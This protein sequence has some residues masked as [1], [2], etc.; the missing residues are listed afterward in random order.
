[1][2]LAQNKVAQFQIGVDCPCRAD[3][4]DVVYTVK[5]V[6][7]VAVNAD[8]RYAHATCHDGNALTLVSARVTLHATHVVDKHGVGEVVFGNVFGAE[9]IARHKHGRRKI[10]CF[11]GD[12]WGRYWHSVPP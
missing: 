3:T 12:V 7:L 11:C 1:M 9:R 2:R 6:Q 10:A 8:G 4:N 5:V